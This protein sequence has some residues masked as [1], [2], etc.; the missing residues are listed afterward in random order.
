MAKGQLDRASI[1]TTVTTIG[2]RLLTCAIAVL[3]YGLFITH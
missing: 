1:G 2:A 3:V